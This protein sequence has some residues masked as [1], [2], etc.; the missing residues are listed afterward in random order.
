LSGDWH[1]WYE[2]QYGQRLANGQAAST[3]TPAPSSAAA[4]GRD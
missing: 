3:V 1:G 2:R 4:P